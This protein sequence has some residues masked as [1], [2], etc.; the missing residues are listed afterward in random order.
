MNVAPVP[1]RARRVPFRPIAEGAGL[2]ALH[3]H[4]IEEL[5]LAHS[6][7]CTPLLLQSNARAYFQ[8]HAF[9]DVTGKTLGQAIE[10]DLFV[11]EVEGA[12]DVEK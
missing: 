12:V 7:P 6:H 1:H 3:G 5:D 2:R 11:T 10:D 8:V 4:D 9:E